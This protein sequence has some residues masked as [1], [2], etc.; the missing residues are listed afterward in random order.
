MFLRRRGE[1]PKSLVHDD[2]ATATTPTRKKQKTEEPVVVA[3]KK[4]LLGKKKDKNKKSKT[5]QNQSKN[6]RLIPT[7][8]EHYAV[9][10]CILGWA[11]EYCSPL[12]CMVGFSGFSCEILPYYGFPVLTRKPIARGQLPLYLESTKD[13]G[14][15]LGAAHPGHIREAI[16]N[17]FCLC[18]PEEDPKAAKWELW[19]IWSFQSQYYPPEIFKRGPATT[20]D[21]ADEILSGREFG[22]LNRTLPKVVSTIDQKL[23]TFPVRLREYYGD[24]P[25]SCGEPMDSLPLNTTFLDYQE[26]LQ[27]HEDYKKLLDDKKNADTEPIKLRKKSTKKRL[28]KAQ[29]SSSDE[30][31]NN[32]QSSEDPFA[33]DMDADSQKENG[34]STDQQ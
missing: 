21:L 13:K 16:K 25:I 12:D 4:K 31:E 20:K 11:I 14:Y 18:F 7:T 26:L 9:V 10:D 1:R 2:T 17:A 5:T 33:N 15:F 29:E 34:S 27:L 30:L 24:K 32:T 8:K 22:G 23:Y 19:E 28:S 6:E 3:T